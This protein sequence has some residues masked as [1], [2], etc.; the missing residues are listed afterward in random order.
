MA[1]RGSIRGITPLDM[2]LIFIYPWIRAPIAV[3]IEKRS[4]ERFMEITPAPTGVL[5]GEAAS[6]AP[7]FHAIKNNNTRPNINKTWFS[8]VTA[9]IGEN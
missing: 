8:T 4:M 9:P 1:P 3:K 6:L 7:R 5:H 2:V